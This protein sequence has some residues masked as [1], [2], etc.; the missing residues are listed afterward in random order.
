M[1]RPPEPQRRDYLSD[2]AYHRDWYGWRAIVRDEEL[3]CAER[4]AQWEVIDL[5]MASATPQPSGERDR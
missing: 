2:E 5:A 1:S 4:E 3:N